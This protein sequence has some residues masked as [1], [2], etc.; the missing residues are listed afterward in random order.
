M[1]T[2]LSPDTTA[3]TRVLDDCAQLEERFSLWQARYQELQGFAFPGNRFGGIAQLGSIYDAG[4][5]QQVQD[6]RSVYVSEWV[7]TRG[8][9]LT[10]RRTQSK[11][12]ILPITHGD[13]KA[14]KLVDEAVV[15]W[16]HSVYDQL[17]N[18][19]VRGLGGFSWDY[20]MKQMGTWTGKEAFMVRVYDAGGYLK[21]ECPLIDP[22]NLY[23]DIDVLEGQQLR[24]I[25]HFTVRWGDVAKAAYGWL[26]GRS[27]GLTVKKPDGKKDDESAVCKDYW[28]RD[29]DGKIHHAIL[30]DGQPIREGVSWQDHGHRRIPIVIAS[31]PSASHGFQG[32]KHGAATVAD[33]VAYYHAEPFFARAIS[34]LRFLQGLE[35]LAADG[36]ALAALPVF[37]H[38]RD[39]GRQGVRKQEIKPFALLEMT[40]NEQ[41][42]VLRGINEGKVPLDNAIQRIKAELNDIY[43]DHLVAPA[44]SSN[45]SGFSFNSQIISQARMFMVPWTRMD[46]AVKS[47]LLSC[48]I[49]QHQHAYPDLAFRLSGIMPEGGKFSRQFA[50]SDY[51]T[52]E[53]R[54]DVREPAEI[55][56]EEMQNLQAAISAVQAGGISWRTARLTK[57]G[58]GDPQREQDRID[59]EAFEASQ[60]NQNWQKLL[61]FGKMADELRKKARR[62]RGQSEKMAAEIALAQIEEYLEALRM[63]IKGAPETGFTMQP[64]AGAP[65]PA[66]MPPQA[67]V[68]DPSM[69]ALSQGRPPSGTQGR[70]RPK[71]SR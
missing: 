45:I 2:T 20:Q 1:V 63:Q 33:T 65:A 21:V 24:I 62:A 7:G 9:A 49:D 54:I 25:R 43:P 61:R 71:G 6:A 22:M 15:Q 19:K 52:G 38:R 35:A 51:P 48:V 26:G 36:A 40:T 70:P 69:A 60:E 57:M 18:Q 12:T 66:Q 41:L 27:G 67:G 14:A 56:G 29:P 37:I 23:H 11:T 8:E 68:D 50:V 4:S 34:P 42:E 31:R 3:L 17:E 55:P 53:F 44:L 5:A 46:E 28:R 47:E 58:I 13:D 64:E 39:G 32:M 10:N 16:A 30:V 59:D